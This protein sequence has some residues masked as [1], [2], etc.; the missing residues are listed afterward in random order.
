MLPFQEVSPNIANQ[1][2]L[3]KVYQSK[4]GILYQ[5]DCLKLLSALPN[6]SVELVFADPTFNRG[7]QYGEGVSDRTLVVYCAR[8][9]RYL[10]LLY[11]TKPLS[12]AIS[13][14]LS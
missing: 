6:E 4:H 7:K 1:Q 12:Y 10:C 14:C 13:N 2:G 11:G 3:R 8:G 9:D 5:G